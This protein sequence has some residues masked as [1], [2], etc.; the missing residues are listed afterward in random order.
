MKHIKRTPF[1][2]MLCL[3]SFFSCKPTDMVSPRELNALE[4]KEAVEAMPEFQAFKQASAETHDAMVQNLAN[5][6][7]QDTKWINLMHQK[8][9]TPEAFASNGETQELAMYKELTGLDVLEGNEENNVLFQDFIFTLRLNASYD[10]LELGPILFPEPAS[11]GSQKF[12]P[13]CETYCLYEAGRQRRNIYNQCVQV[14]IGDINH[15]IRC[16]RKA[17]ITFKYYL[18]KC[19]SSCLGY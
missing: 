3:L 10:P 7:K 6:D 4:L 19:L 8:Y 18:L 5:L 15:E 16:A 9:P 13:S 1:I 2:L 12:F 11:T 14:S 17:E